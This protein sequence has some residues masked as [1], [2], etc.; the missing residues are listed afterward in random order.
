MRGACG[1]VDGLCAG[2]LWVLEEERQCAFYS[3]GRPEW[4]LKGNRRGPCR[5]I[6]IIDDLIKTDLLAK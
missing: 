6:I 3:R 1:C 2:E 5:K 4:Q